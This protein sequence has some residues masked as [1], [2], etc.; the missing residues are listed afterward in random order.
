[1]HMTQTQLRISFMWLLVHLDL[2][3]STV[4]QIQT[5]QE[6]ARTNCISQFWSQQVINHEASTNQRIIHKIFQLVGLGLTQVYVD[7]IADAHNGPEDILKDSSQSSKLREHSSGNSL[8][9][10][11]TYDSTYSVR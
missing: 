9:Q 5:W 11:S 2:I 3:P 10:M 6:L 7:V 8:A 1:M 4:P